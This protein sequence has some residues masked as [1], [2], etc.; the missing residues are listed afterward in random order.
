MTIKRLCGRAGV[1]AAV[2]TTAL[3][4]SGAAMAQQVVHIGYSGPLSG[5][6]A[7]YGQEVLE[8]MQMAAADVNQAGIEVAGKKIKLEIVPLDDKYNPAETAINARRLAQ[9]QQAAV[10]L[11]PHSGGGFAVQ[12]SNEQQKLLLLSYTSVPQITERGNKL[13]VRIPPSFTS[14]LDSFVKYEM[15]TYGK[16]VALA[17]TD[18]DYGKVWV[19]AFKPAWEAAGGTIVADNAM[20]Y[21]RATDFYSGVS[22]VLAA[23]PDVMFIGGPSEPTGL[24]AQ[25]ARELGFK[26]GFIIMDQ[27]KLDEVAKVT[28]GYAAL[29]GAI[30]VLPLANDTTPNAK[31]FVER[32]RKSH[33]G[34]D[35]SQEVSLNYTAVYATAL[36]MKLAGSVS[37]ATA[38]RNQF[39]KAV[40]ALPPQAN[41]QSVTGVDDHGGFVI[42]K[43]LAAVVQGGQL[44]SADLSSLAAAK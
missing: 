1:V 21:N 16:K 7:K 23:K 33:D 35:P 8:G 24:I 9:E 30:G 3:L 10:V 18:T 25:Q 6:A 27:A 12:T 2:A 34:R 37:D 31:M 32:Y 26:G 22:R 17:A 36:A 15:A 28:G 13:T 40:K 4:G 19:A 39:D 43:P 41:P 5:G 20:S 11:V 29:N 14:Y 38:I 42:G 44:K